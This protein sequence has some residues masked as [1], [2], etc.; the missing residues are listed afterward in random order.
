M[1]ITKFGSRPDGA[2]GPTPTPAGLIPHGVYMKPDGSVSASGNLDMDQH[3]IIGVGDPTLDQDAA[4]KTYVD[5]TT[6]TQAATTFTNAKDY[7]DTGLTDVT[8]K[9]T[10]ADGMARE[11]KGKADSAFAAISATNNRVR[12]LDLTAT[13]A[14]DAAISASTK[15]DEAKALAATANTTANEAKTLASAA[16]PP[17]PPGTGWY[18]HDIEASD[19]APLST[20]IPADHTGDYLVI[21][22][23]TRGV[24][25]GDWLDVSCFFSLLNGAV[26]AAQERVNVTFTGVKIVHT[27][28]NHDWTT[29]AT[30]GI[31]AYRGTTRAYTDGA[32]SVHVKL[33][34]TTNNSKGLDCADRSMVIKHWR[35]NN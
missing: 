25:K 24:L 35:K 6:A 27:L 32:G 21:D 4:S 28:P 11:A 10:G 1:P 26:D 9:A 15:A 16:P 34:I 12:T 14:H 8:T 19:R 17:P 3:K 18:V 22:L 31:R 20:I 29:A 5:S 13:S 2:R 23:N 33:L 30:P 7:V